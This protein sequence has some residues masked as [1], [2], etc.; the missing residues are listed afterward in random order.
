[1]VCENGANPV[2]MIFSREVSMPLLRLL[3]KLDAATAEHA[4]QEMGSFVVFLND[5][6][7]LPERLKAAAEKHALKHVVLTVD[8]PAGPEGF[9]VAREADVTVVLYLDHVVKANHA[10]RKGELND[11][12]IA[13]ILADL[14]KIV[15]R[16]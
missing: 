7:N 13:K 11:E 8:Q 5:D 3:A 10:F 6:A 16:P 4:K 14:P 12:A 1:M 9:K 2:A 15:G